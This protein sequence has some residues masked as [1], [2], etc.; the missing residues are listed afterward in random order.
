MND[1]LIPIPVPEEM[2][3]FDE[4]QTA[5]SA[6]INRLYLYFIAFTPSLVV[7]LILLVAGIVL[8]RLII[9]ILGRGLKK[10]PIDRSAHAF[11]VSVVRTLLYLIVFVTVLAVLGIPM[12]SLIAVI[13]SAGL[14]IG[15]SMQS[16]LSNVAAGIILLA[17][18]PFKVGDFI[19]VN[20]VSGTVDEISVISIKLISPDNKVVYLPNN[21]VSSATITN[22]TEQPTRR[23]ELIL[24]ISSGSDYKKAIKIIENAVSKHE[25]IFAEP[26]PFI[27]LSNITMRTAEITARFWVESENFTDVRHDIISLIKDSFDKEGIV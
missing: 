11:M 1:E 24:K 8:N 3:T 9:M 10:S 13:G 6:L 19:D 14:A 18:K 4:I 21:A 5:G 17:G 2:M 25:K 27:K 16:S 26:A 22:F 12:T 7:A 23:I 15:L 20:G